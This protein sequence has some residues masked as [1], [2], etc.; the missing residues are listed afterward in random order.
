MGWLCCLKHTTPTTLWA[1]IYD[2]VVSLV[3]KDDRLI[4]TAVMVGVEFVCFLCLSC[5][6][7]L[8]EDHLSRWRIE[9][10]KDPKSGLVKSAFNNAFVAIFTH[11]LIY[12]MMWPAWKPNLI[13]NAE[14]PSWKMFL[15]FNY[16]SFATN[17]VFFYFAHRLFHEI[18]ALYKLHKQH[19]EFN[20]TK[21]IAAEYAHIA[22][23]ILSN[24]LPTLSGAIIWFKVV[25]P[26]HL[27]IL[28]FYLLIRLIETTENHSGFNFP[29]TINWLFPTH[30]FDYG[31]NRGVSSFHY[32]HHSHNTGNYG[33]PFMDW[34]MGTDKTYRK[35]VDQEVEK[36]KKL[37]KED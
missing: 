25:G 31:R 9:K 11:I 26:L 32:F 20:F 1:P 36:R 23:G 8:F 14:A 29:I 22:E 15:I 12:Y 4:F 13:I 21:G 27:S 19:H 34:L 30:W 37:K 2:L 18:P 5:L 35:F 10:K 6:L 3:G 16:F 17:E 7:W 24:F 33:T 28:F